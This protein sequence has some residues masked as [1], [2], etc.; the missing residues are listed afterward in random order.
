MTRLTIVLDDPEK[1]AL[2]ELAAVEYREPQA[3]AAFIIRQELARRGF[4]PPLA[5]ELH[6]QKS[7]INPPQEVTVESP[8]AA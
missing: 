1:K 4:I 6:A 8:I 3:Q 2:R 5:I 7:A